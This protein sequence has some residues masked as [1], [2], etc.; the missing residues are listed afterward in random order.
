[1]RKYR[2]EP[3]TQDDQII[4]LLDCD[5]L[6][7]SKY[8]KTSKITKF[9]KKLKRIFKSKTKTKTKTKTKSNK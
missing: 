5:T 4:F 3:E 2:I 8:K 1:M 9:W 7:I 6:L